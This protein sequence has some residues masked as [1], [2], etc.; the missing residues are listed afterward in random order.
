ME[1]DKTLHNLGL[2]VHGVLAAFHSLGVLYN[3]RRGNRGQAAL[4]GLVLI[5][6]LWAVWEHYLELEKEETNESPL[7]R[8]AA[9][10]GHCC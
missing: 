5:Y 1:D 10:A 8:T 4:H 7:A 3:L 2:F 9:L 6:D